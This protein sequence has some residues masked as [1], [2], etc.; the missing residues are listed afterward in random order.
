MHYY[1]LGEKWGKKKEWAVYGSDTKYYII[2]C[3]TRRNSYGLCEDDD[4]KA[5]LEQN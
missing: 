3:T 1:S 4:M 2:Q 5:F